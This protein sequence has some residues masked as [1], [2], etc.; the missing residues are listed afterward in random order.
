VAAIGNA[1]PQGK[2]SDLLPDCVISEI[3]TVTDLNIISFESAEKW[4]EWLAE[5]HATSNGIWLRVFKK[6]SGEA[7]VYY[8]EALDEA[9]CYGW[10]DGQGRKYDEQ[11]YLQKF[12]P[13]RKGSVWSKRNTEHVERLIKEGRMKPAGLQEVEA[14]KAD[15]RWARAYDSPASMQVPEDFLSEL[16]KMPDALA[17]FQ[18]LSKAN[19]YAIA[20]RLQSAKRPETRQRRMKVILEMLARGEKLYG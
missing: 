10:I 4:G 8:G 13:R 15:G 3:N 11:S 7:S 9:L 17:F 5:N 16:S 20:Y 18:M 19:T 2:M 6:G 12:T 1:G 14:A